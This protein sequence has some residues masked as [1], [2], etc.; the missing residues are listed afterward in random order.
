MKYP[1][2]NQMPSTS[3]QPY[4]MMKTTQDSIQRGLVEELL[5]ALLTALPYVED[6]LSDPEQLKCFKAGAVQKDVKKI[7]EA[8]EKAGSDE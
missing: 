4:S 1:S 6:A 2:T 8:I 7:R 5:E 3:G